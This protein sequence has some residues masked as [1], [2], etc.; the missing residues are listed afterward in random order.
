MAAPALPAYQNSGNYRSDLVIAV[1]ADYGQF[2]NINSSSDLVG[3]DID[4]IKDICNGV[5]CAVMTAP[6][7]SAIAKSYQDLGWSANPKTYPGVGFQNMWYDCIAGARNTIQRQQSL[8]FTPPYTDPSTD[9]AV[10]VGLSS[11]SVATGLSRTS[12]DL[13]TVKVGVQA[14]YAA[15]SYFDAHATTYNALSVHR[16]NTAQQLFS[17]LT[18]GTVDVVFYGKAGLA[19]ASE[20]NSATMTEVGPEVAAWA[21]GNSFMCHPA[22]MWARNKLKSGWA[23]ISRNERLRYNSTYS[24]IHVMV[25]ASGYDGVGTYTPPAPTPTP[26]QTPAPTLTPGQTPAPTPVPPAATSTA[27]AMRAQFAMLAACCIPAIYMV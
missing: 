18:A 20:Y 12:N 17:A 21:N 22:K 8:L 27:Q 14:G 25:E 11:N 7:Q 4:L 2:N 24:Q 23:G 3:L 16:Y 15:T 26:G 9:K 19:G 10:F 1:E 6:W 13:R 5:R